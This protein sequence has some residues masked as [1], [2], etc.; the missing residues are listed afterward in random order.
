[1]FFHNCKEF[2]SQD[3]NVV[4][5]NDVSSVIEA[6]GHQHDS[7]NLRLRTDSSKVSLIAVMLRNWNKFPTVPLA[8]TTNMKESYENMKLLLEKIQYEMHAWNICGLLLSCLA[9]GLAAKSFASFC[10][11]GIVGTDISKNSSLNQNAYSKT[12]KCSKYSINQLWNIKLG[13][14]KNFIK[15]TVQKSAGYMYVN[16]MFPRI[17][18]AEIKEGVYVGSQARSSE[19]RTKNLK[20]S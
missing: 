16:N 15:A 5:C 17:I 12:E 11:S 4:F 8:H 7:T 13:V 2:F 20:T 9:C 1:M 3:S 18:G 14:R 6:L 10:V 19:Y